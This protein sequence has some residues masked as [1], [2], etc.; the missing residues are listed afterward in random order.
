MVRNGRVI[1]VLGGTW[2]FVFEVR[3]LLEGKYGK[4]KKKK[5]TIRSKIRKLI[6]FFLYSDKMTVVWT[7]MISTRVII[8]ALIMIT[9]GSSELIIDV[10][11]VVV[12]CCSTDNWTTLAYN[13]VSLQFNH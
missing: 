1:L 3:A 12:N 2:S 8:A 11:F 4:D 9:N 5:K 6:Q 7:I 13:K 10:G